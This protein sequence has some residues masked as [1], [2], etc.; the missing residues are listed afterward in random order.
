MAFCPNCHAEICRNVSECPGCSDVFGGDD[1]GWTP[2]PERPKT[3]HRRSAQT[4]EPLSKTALFFGGL[5]WAVPATLLL[6]VITLGRALPLFAITVVVGILG[7]LFG[8]AFACGRVFVRGLQGK[9]HPARKLLGHRWG[10]VLGWSAG[11]PAGVLGG[12]GVRF[13]L[14]SKF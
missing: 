8:S 7:A 11:L 12:M 3:R 9:E 6:S 14:F 10:R 1:G 13:V 5:F 2:L 4:A